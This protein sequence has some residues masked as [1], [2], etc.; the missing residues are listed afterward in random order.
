MKY[1]LNLPSQKGGALIISMLLLTLLGLLTL[2]S[3]R[4]SL[5]Q[6]QMSV[7]RK[8]INADFLSAENVLFTLINSLSAS[9]NNFVIQDYSKL[10]FKGIVELQCSRAFYEGWSIAENLW[11]DAST[12]DSRLA[13]TQY[14]VF[15]PPLSCIQRE[16]I[17]SAEV[18]A[19]TN[20]KFYWV[21]SRSASG[22]IILSQ[23]ADW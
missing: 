2:Y 12:I 21:L 7:T 15:R 6:S 8:Q 5:L 20:T 3:M 17:A 9:Q 10:S 14:A 23:Y 13:G 22:N 19:T 18:G 4:N 1:R 16:E 11:Q